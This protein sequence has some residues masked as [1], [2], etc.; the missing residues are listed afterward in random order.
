MSVLELKAAIGRRVYL[1]GE[2]SPIVTIIDVKTAY[3]RV[4][5]QVT[6]ESGIGSTWVTGSRLNPV[7]P[8]GNYLQ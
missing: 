8:D 1:R 5:Y 2:V 7:E 4:L 3:G 6:P